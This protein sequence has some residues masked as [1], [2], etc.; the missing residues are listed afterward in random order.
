[1]FHSDDF[2]SAREEAARQL[3]EA[4]EAFV[5]CAGP[6]ERECAE[7][8]RMVSRDPRLLDRVVRKF[9]ARIV[10]RWQELDERKEI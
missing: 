9:G 5:Q 4:S 2:L 8:W 7:L 3:M 1:M 6:G 10:Q